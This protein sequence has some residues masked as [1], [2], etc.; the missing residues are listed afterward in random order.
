MTIKEIAQIAGVSTSTVSKIMNGKD[1]SIR[2]ETREKVLN[3]AKEY[4][5]VPYSGVRLGL[6]TKNFM[7]G[8]VLG[9][10][11]EDELLLRGIHK[12]AG[13]SGY[14]VVCCR[15]DGTMGEEQ[16]AV[17]RI[18]RQSV[19]G[20]IWRRTSQES[21]IYK[22]YADEKEIVCLFCDGF[23][24]DY[25]HGGMFQDY[26]RL[27]YQA[28]AYLVERKHRKL[29]C[30]M[31]PGNRHSEHFLKGFQRCLYEH[32]IEYDRELA[33]FW[34]DTCS[35]ND[36]MLYGT[37][38]IVC[39][40]ERIADDVMK[41]AAIHAY[42]VPEELSVIALSNE[43]YQRYG[44][45]HLTSLVIP[46]RGLGE[47]VCSRLI[48]WIE[49]HNTE[50]EGFA[51]PI[52]FVTGRSVSVVSGRR[53]KKIV[54][55]GSVN[56]DAVINVD[57]FPESGQTIIAKQFHLLPGGK[58]FNQAVGAA[59]LGAR[60]YLIGVV[61]QD[62]E[63]KQ[64]TDVMRRSG[65]WMDGMTQVHTAS[66]GKA[67]ITVQSNGESSV[68]VYPGANQLLSET[69]IQTNSSIF[70]DAS[71]CLMQ[72]EIPIKTIEYAAKVAEEKGVKV[73]L[74]PAVPQRIND[75]LL[76]KVYILVPNEKEIHQLIPGSQTLE[77]KAQYVLDQ[78]V[79]HII[80]TLGEKGCYLRSEN[81]SLY[82]SAA[83]FEAVDTTGAADAF[84]SCLAVF[85]AEGLTMVE[86]IKYAVYAAGI[87]ITMQGAQSALADRETLERYR[88][89]IDSRIQVWEGR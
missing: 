53:M 25:G 75:A 66:T 63:A 38:G 43:D 18:C 7:I 84:L 78:G 65:V 88:D 72:T 67:Y 17:V 31:E 57:Q 71:F 21:T 50:Q 37:T 9:D 1:T 52:E 6:A 59:R 55:V 4:Q 51:Q 77:E 46:E 8:A 16:K 39:L 79:R 23:E 32:Q 35:V 20:M 69:E 26:G 24:A 85:L 13:R 83:E 30:L 3:I 40:N 48:H 54:V 49:H 11:L 27:G 29:G 87:S 41:Q 64:M 12:E 62:Y 36:L 74:K 70:E 86:A 80:V 47:S 89:E 42:K 58:G 22:K 33:R 15:H 28:A 2:L 10:G 56:M 14:S 76:K 81:S 68:I 60:A 44:N 19:D 61:G 82:F 5:Y 73:I 34:D 45:P